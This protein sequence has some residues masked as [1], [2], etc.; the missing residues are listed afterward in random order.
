MAINYTAIIADLKKPTGQILLNTCE[1]LQAELDRRRAEPAYSNHNLISSKF[2]TFIGHCFTNPS[3]LP[4]EINGLVEPIRKIN[5]D[6]E[7]CLAVATNH[8]AD[9]CDALS[10]LVQHFNTMAQNLLKFEQKQKDDLETEQY[11][12]QYCQKV[13]LSAEGALAARAEQAKHQAMLATG[14]AQAITQLDKLEI[15]DCRFAEKI[16]ALN[17]ITRC[18]V[19]KMQEIDTPLYSRLFSPFDYATQTTMSTPFYWL[20]GIH[21]WSDPAAPI[22]A[23]QTHI[24]GSESPT[25][26]LDSDGE[27]IPPLTEAT[28]HTANTELV[29]LSPV[30]SIADLSCGAARLSPR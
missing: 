29:P 25:V 30:L 12:S 13:V 4:I 15:L 3:K 26:C 10:T 21:S 20:R 1:H 14:I 24:A 17:G 18:A 28:T 5:L 9:Y 16:T 19:I 22:Q 23:A 2:S 11:F 7:A 27:E 8:H 6:F